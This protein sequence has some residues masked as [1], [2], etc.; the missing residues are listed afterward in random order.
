MREMYGIECAR[1]KI[2][3]EI[4]KSMSVSDASSEHVLLLSDEMCSNGNLTSIQKTGLHSRDAGNVGL[5]LAFQAPIQVI[6]KAAVNGVI[7]RVEGISANFIY[8]QIPSVGTTYNDILVNEQFVENW[9]QNYNQ[10]LES[11]I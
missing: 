7:D 3:N 6:E 8:G 4:Q 10:K 11:V 5:Q 2:V 1:L 9:F